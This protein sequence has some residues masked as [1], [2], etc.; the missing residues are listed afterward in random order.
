M[1]TVFRCIG[2]IGTSNYV[3]DLFSVDYVMP[4]DKVE[5]TESYPTGP[6]PDRFGA[7]I[8]TSTGGFEWTKFPDP[9]FPV[10]YHEGKIK[11]QDT[12]E[13]LSINA[14]SGDIEARVAALEAAI[15]P[16]AP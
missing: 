12:M 16:P 3:C 2:T 8:I 11:N 1:T 4:D 5:I 9:P 10:V 14:L 15:S 6:G 13:Q 7:W